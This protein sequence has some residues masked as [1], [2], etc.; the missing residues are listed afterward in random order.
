MRADAPIEA[1]AHQ[2]PQG[3]GELHFATLGGT[4]SALKGHAAAS[5]L[6]NHLLPS[7]CDLI[8][9]HLQSLCPGTHALDMRGRQSGSD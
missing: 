9:P 6:A 4:V 5:P 7:R 8:E 2:A 1:M 3:D